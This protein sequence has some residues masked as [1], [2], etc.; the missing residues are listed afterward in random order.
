MSVALQAVVHAELNEA[1][2]CCADPTEDL[3]ENPVLAVF[4]KYF[5]PIML[6]SEWVSISGLA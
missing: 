6:E 1:L 5:E 2:I 4:R 3:L